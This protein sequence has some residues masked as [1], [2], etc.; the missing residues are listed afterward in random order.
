MPDKEER[1]R[2]KNFLIDKQYQL[3]YPGTWILMVAFALVNFVIVNLLVQTEVAELDRGFFAILQMVGRANAA[4]I[5]LAGAWMGFSSIRH[6]HRIAGAIFNINRTV[7]RVLEGDEK[8]E[9][10]LRK[11]DFSTEIAANIN[12]L[13]RRLRE[14]E[15]RAEGASPEHAEES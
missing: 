11:E 4:L 9:V 12:E 6:S 7:E 10:R 1:R 14:C 8:A 3:Y 5:L 15:A 13:I 2:F